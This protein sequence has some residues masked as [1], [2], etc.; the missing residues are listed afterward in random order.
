M[1][2]RAL[3]LLIR[4]VTNIDHALVFYQQALGFRVIGDRQ[5][6]PDL[7]TLL[8]FNG[9]IQTICLQ[10]GAQKIMLAC[11][12]PPGKAYRLGSNAADLW[13][14]HIAIV[15]ADIQSSYE[16]LQFH[17]AVPISTGGPQTLP[18]SSGGALAY[19]CRDHDGHPLELISLPT[20]KRHAQGGNLG[21]DHSAIS[22]GDIERS[23]GFYRDLLGLS[24]SAHQLN[25][26]QAQDRLDRLD[27][28]AVD[29]VAMLPQDQPCPHIELL[30]Y[31]Q[32]SGRMASC[33]TCASDIA[34][35]RLV[36]EVDDLPSLLGQ[37]QDCEPGSVLRQGQFAGTNAALIHDPDGHEFIL[38]DRE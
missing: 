33:A 32:P 37:L 18:A 36:L 30:G 28:V 5:D 4:N 20:T 15:T 26:G 22:V 25:Q 16:S 8:S 3:R 19:K 10:L 2:V 11:Y 35:D 9:T 29:V 6:A 23:I 24:L 7:A 34:A 12:D 21:Y 27:A 31:R 1:A 14:Q 13:F 38:I 17:G